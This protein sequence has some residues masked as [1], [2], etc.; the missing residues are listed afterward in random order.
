MLAFGPRVDLARTHG[1]YLPAAVQKACSA[2]M[3]N[4]VASKPQSCKVTVHVGEG[5]LE[6]VLQ[7]GR[8]R[9]LDG[10]SVVEH[11]T[12]HHNVPM[13]LEREGALVPLLKRELIALL[14]C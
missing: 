7:A 5:N 9:G 14:L 3:L 8:L 2:D 6:D 1:S 10:V 11:D 13:H 4:S 12:F